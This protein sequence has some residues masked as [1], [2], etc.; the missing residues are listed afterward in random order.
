MKLSKDEIE[1]A[2]RIVHSMLLEGH[3]LDLNEA[4]ELLKKSKQN[5]D[6]ERLTLALAEGKKLGLS[7]VEAINKFFLNK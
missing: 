4:L 2:K 5:K 1:Q 3:K 6:K 7:D